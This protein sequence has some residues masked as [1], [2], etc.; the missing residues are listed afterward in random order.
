MVILAK[1]TPKILSQIA[2]TLSRAKFYINH[3]ERNN[4]PYSFPMERLFENFNDSV[5]SMRREHGIDFDVKSYLTTTPQMSKL[6]KAVSDTFFKNLCS[7][8]FFMEIQQENMA[9]YGYLLR[10]SSVC[11]LRS[12]MEFF[13]TTFAYKPFTCHGRVGVYKNLRVENYRPF[14]FT[15]EEFD[16]ELKLW[17]SKYQILEDEKIP[18]NIPESHWW[19]S[20][21]AQDKQK[22]FS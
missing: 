2:V 13:F 20:M 21:A 3:I 16:V 12:G 15:R 10:P 22:T 11:R 6:S 8:I 9:D 7:V 14:I 1:D 18:A 4:V 19:W 17:T 5:M